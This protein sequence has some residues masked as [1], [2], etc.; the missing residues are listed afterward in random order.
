MPLNREDYA[1]PLCPL[2]MRPESERLPLGRI[3]A[4]L[5]G[6]LA[7]KDYP[8]AE[9]LLQSWL[10]E[11]ESGGDRAGR[12]TLLNE[13]I[14]L[15][16]KTGQKQPCLDA[17]AAALPLVEELR[18]SD[19]VT[20]GTTFVNAATGYKAFG[21]A[22]EALPLY[23]RAEE[24]YAR[25]LDPADDRFAALYNN[26]ALT[27][28]ELRRYDEAEALYQKALGVLERQERPELEKAITYLNLAD[29]AAARL[30]P[31]AAEPLVYDYLTRAEGLLDTETLPRDGYYAFV[32]EKCAPVFD[33]YGFFM[34]KLRLEQRAKEIYERT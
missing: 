7:Q 5:D 30:G 3:L 23:R 8:A 14:G 28:T 32:C 33:Y 17:I 34:A 2:N 4:K 12:L 19:T 22:E 26:M 13:Q 25:R 18:F 1:E 29:L 10:S 20:G 21:L 16:R 11:A 9:R 15:Y 27:L 24:A 6:L 31:E